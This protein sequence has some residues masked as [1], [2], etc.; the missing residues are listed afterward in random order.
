MD[1]QK[2]IVKLMRYD[3]EI[4]YRPGYENVAVD[5]LSHLHRELASI[6]YPQPIW[7]EVV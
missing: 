7:L 5:A 6:T 2:W 1:Q 4:E 3:Y